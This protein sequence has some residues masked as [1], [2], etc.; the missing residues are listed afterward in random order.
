MKVLAPEARGEMKKEARRFLAVT[1]PELFTYKTLTD[2]V[3]H[4]IHQVS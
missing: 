4:F 3:P 2:A 1:S